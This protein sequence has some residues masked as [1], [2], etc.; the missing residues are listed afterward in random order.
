MVKALAFTIA[1]FVGLAAG[2]GPANA[3]EY[4][5]D[6]RLT[7]AAR[8]ETRCYPGPLPFVPVASG[9]YWD[10]VISLSGDVCR[11]ID[12][13]FT[14]RPLRGQ[15]LARAANGWHVFAHEYAHHLGYDHGEQTIGADVAGER[16]ERHLMARCDVPQNLRIRIQRYTVHEA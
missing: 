12:L 10:D 3:A 13:A 1:I 4:E 7:R 8:A 14:V 6:Q 11:N 2:P 5:I 16:L 9:A 15:A